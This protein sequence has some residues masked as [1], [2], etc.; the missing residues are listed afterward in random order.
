MAKARFVR[1]REGDPGRSHQK[2]RR[3]CKGK[4]D[5]VFPHQW[6]PGKLWAEGLLFQKKRTKY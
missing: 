3:Y 2:F 4:P 1:G 5:S 6:Q